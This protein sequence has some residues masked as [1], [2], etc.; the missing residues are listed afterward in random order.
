MLFLVY[1]LVVTPVG[2]ASR[3]FHDPLTRRR[4]RRANTYWVEPVDH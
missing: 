3:L 1:F 2:M 4:R